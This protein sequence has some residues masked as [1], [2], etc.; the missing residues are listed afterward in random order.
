M[1]TIL[2]TGGSGLVGRRLTKMLMERGYK[3]LWLSRESD[4]ESDP[5]RYSW[6]YRNRKI[7]REAVEQADVIIHLAGANLGEGRWSEDRKK[8]I[9]ASRVDTAGLLFDTL[10]ESEHQ[11]EAFISASAIGYYGAAVT[12][13]VFTEEEQPR[14]HDFLSDTCRQWEEA[15][16][17]FNTL[18]GV[19]TVALRTGFVVDRDSDAFKKM[20]L[21]TRLGVGSPLGSGR[22]YLSWIHLEDLC[23]L[24]IRAVE[25][26]TMEGVYNAVAPEEIT[27][28]DFMHT[29]AKEMHRPFFFPAVPSFVMRLVMGEAADLVLGGS[30]ISAQKILDSGFRFRYEH[31]EE[32]IRASLRNT[33]R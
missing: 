20:V 14:E 29:L 7:D 24:Y 12:D 25:E 23:R 3:V 13:N 19:R 31:A 30:S 16:F 4:P 15:A 28:A 11:I 5:P 6:D 10:Q 32:A 18:P 21:P 1:K 33:D 22:Q 8:E 2:V 17:R 27:N 26:A 9:V